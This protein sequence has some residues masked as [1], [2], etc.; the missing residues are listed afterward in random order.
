V[1]VKKI[2]RAMMPISWALYGKEINQKDFLTIGQQ[3]ISCSKRELY[4]W[5]CATMFVN[6]V[7]IIRC[8]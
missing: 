5:I 2:F 6:S 7:D 3:S 1:K 4:S 8:K